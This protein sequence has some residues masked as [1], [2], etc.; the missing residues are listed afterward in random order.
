[1]VESN[2]KVRL[3]ETGE[4][5]NLGDLPNAITE[6]KI[7]S[8]TV[9]GRTVDVEYF[10]ILERGITPFFTLKYTDHGEKKEIVRQ[11]PKV[12]KT[13]FENGIVYEIET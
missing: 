13:T 8:C 12:K 1:M 5:K 10:Q 3:H 7:H 2:I 4:A 6:Y 11:H 9:D